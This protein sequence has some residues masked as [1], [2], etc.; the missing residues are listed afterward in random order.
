MKVYGCDVT[1]NSVVT[2]RTIV[3]AADK[4]DAMRKIKDGDI[5]DIIDVFIERDDISDV[6]WFS[7]EDAE[8]DE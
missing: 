5:D 4:D 1:Y 7:E 2:E 6:Y 8:E 3:T